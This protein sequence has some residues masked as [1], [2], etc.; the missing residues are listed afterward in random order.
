MKVLV[1]ALRIQVLFPLEPKL[2]A[3]CTVSRAVG[4][5]Q[6]QEAVP[7]EREGRDTIEDCQGQA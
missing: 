3:V 6:R 5:G 2:Q 4:W 7:R 1:I